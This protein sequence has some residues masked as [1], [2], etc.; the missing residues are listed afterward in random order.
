MEKIFISSFHRS[1]KKYHLINSQSEINVS[2]SSIMLRPLRSNIGGIKLELILA[3]GSCLVN[4]EMNEIRNGEYLK[5]MT[6][7]IEE[8][9]TDAGYISISYGNNWWGDEDL[10]RSMG[11]KKD[12]SIFTKKLSKQAIVRIQQ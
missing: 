5:N 1:L 6:T 8:F 2:G 12:G 4:V 11:Y 10:A 3:L 7:A 9:C